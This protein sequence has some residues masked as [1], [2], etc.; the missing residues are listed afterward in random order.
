MKN[1]KLFWFSSSSIVITL[2]LIFIAILK[3]GPLFNFYI[4]PPSPQNYTKFA[5]SSME[6]QGLYTKGKN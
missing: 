5:L 1:K 6:E 4:I 2:V 3:I